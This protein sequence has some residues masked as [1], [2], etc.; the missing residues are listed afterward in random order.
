MQAALLDIVRYPRITLTA[1]TL[2]GRRKSVLHWAVNEFAHT[3]V[4][5]RAIDQITPVYAGW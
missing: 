1:L 4:P 2:G 3:G 5:Y